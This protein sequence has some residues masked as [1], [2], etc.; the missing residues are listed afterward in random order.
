MRH[1]YLDI[2]KIDL[3]I[4]IVDCCFSQYFELEDGLIL[5]E[6][7]SRS[8]D[9][10]NFKMLQRGTYIEKCTIFIGVISYLTV[11]LMLV[12]FLSLKLKMNYTVSQLKQLSEF[13]S[14]YEC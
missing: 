8:G 7:F 9:C 6:K 4:W 13:Y 10:M 14:N 3:Y 1:V 12:G 2:W 5:C 11:S